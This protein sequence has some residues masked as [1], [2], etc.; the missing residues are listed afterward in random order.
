MKRKKKKAVSP[1][2]QFWKLPHCSVLHFFF[3]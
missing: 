1:W 2:R 3:F